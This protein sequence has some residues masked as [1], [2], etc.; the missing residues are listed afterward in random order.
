MS[1]E[2]NKA[3]VR[4]LVVAADQREFD[5]VQRLLAPDFLLHLAGGR[6]PI[7]REQFLR[8]HE[9]RTTA[10]P[11]VSHTFEAQIAE[12]DLVATRMTQRGTHSGEYMSIPATGRRTSMTGIAIHR[13]V[14]GKVAEAWPSPDLLGL[15]QQL[16]GGPPSGR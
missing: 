12:G 5:L 6:E 11:D 9:A 1:R 13:V 7:D 14:G 4:R 15:L 8:M 16:G 2:E 10:F 3:L